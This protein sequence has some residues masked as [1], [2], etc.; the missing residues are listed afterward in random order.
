MSSKHLD[1]KN[2]GTGSNY[3][4][5]EERQSKPKPGFNIINIGKKLLQEKKKKQDEAKE[6]QIQTINQIS[7]RQDNLHEKEALALIEDSDDEYERTKRS[8]IS[9]SAN[10]TPSR[11]YI[12]KKFQVQKERE[13]ILQERRKSIMNPDKGYMSHYMK[14]VRSSQQSERSDSAS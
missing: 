3:S 5:N 2:T 14:S 13:R 11:H 7:V 1:H 6:R 12:L 8:M 4:L 9:K 10:L